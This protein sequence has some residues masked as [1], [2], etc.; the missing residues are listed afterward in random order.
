MCFVVQHEKNKHL[1][2]DTTCNKTNTQAHRQ[3]WCIMCWDWT[4]ACNKLHYLCAERRLHMELIRRETLEASLCVPISMA[5]CTHVCVWE[6]RH[7]SSVS[8]ATFLLLWTDKASLKIIT[9]SCKKEGKLLKCEMES[10]G[11]HGE[12]KEQQFGSLGLR[13][14]LCSS[15]LHRISIE[16]ELREDRVQLTRTGL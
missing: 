11:R 14:A 5:V 13:D 10:R 6:T 8:K 4:K 3:W 2:H 1:I 16:E 9:W 7:C 15:S 12:L